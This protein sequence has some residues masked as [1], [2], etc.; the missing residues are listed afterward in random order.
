MTELESFNFPSVGGTSSISDSETLYENTSESCHRHAQHLKHSDRTGS[1]STATFS[2]GVEKIS[3]QIVS[4]DA[5]QIATFSQEETPNLPPGTTPLHCA[6]LR[7]HESIARMLIE[8]GSSL[9]CIDAFGRTALH[10]AV[11]QNNASLTKLLLNSKADWGCRDLVGR[12]PLHV[13][14]QSGC[15]VSMCLLMEFVTVLDSLD[16]LGRTALHIAVSSGNEE[17]VKMIVQKGANVNMAVGKP[18]GI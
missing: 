2:S 7:G 6:V 5:P 3:R 1:M 14:A 17:V 10:I 9:D 12:T 15:V 8:C 16:F 4:P 18:V 11:E 13:A